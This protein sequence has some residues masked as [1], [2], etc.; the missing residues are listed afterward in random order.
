MGG[1]TL[2]MRRQ[3]VVFDQTLSK[4]SWEKSENPLHNLRDP[5]AGSFFLFL[6]EWRCAGREVGNVRNV[7]LTKSRVILSRELQSFS[8]RVW[9]CCLRVD[10]SLQGGRASARTQSC[11]C[12]QLDIQTI[13]GMKCVI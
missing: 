1:V 6:L 10:V 3:H 5:A 9:V 13:R 11:L 4:A 12:T 7:G 2:D 8:F